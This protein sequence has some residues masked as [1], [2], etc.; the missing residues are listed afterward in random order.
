M[1][2]LTVSKEEFT[3]MIAGLIVSGVTFEAETVKDN[4]VITFT[5]GY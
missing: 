5:G 2:K 1:R 4:V 3:Q